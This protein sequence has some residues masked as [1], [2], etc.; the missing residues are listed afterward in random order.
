MN[1]LKKNK[2]P[3]LG[4]AAVLALLWVYLTYFSGSSAPLVATSEINVSGDL[5]VT[6]N[7]LHT[8][9]LDA[10][11]FSDPSFASLS[12]FGVAIPPQDAGRR[13]PFSPVGK[14]STPSQ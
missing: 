11:L 6:L 8:I 7:S 9:R 2:T 10:S 4:G 1:F 12:D 3:I 14:T 5:L 13:N